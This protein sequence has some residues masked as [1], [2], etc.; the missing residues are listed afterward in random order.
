MFERYLVPMYLPR[1]VYVPIRSLKRVFVPSNSDADAVETASKCDIKGER[2]IEWSFLSKEMPDGPGEAL[3]FGCED[4]YMSLVA[5]QKGFNVLANDLE[6]QV[7]TWKHP[8]VR[9]LEGDFLELELPRNHFDLAINCS[10]VEHVGVAGRYGITIDNESA[11]LQVM[12]KLADVLKPGRTLLM[13]APC[14]QDTILAPWCRVYGAERL[15]KLLERFEIR[16][17]C[18]W[19]KDDQNTWIRSAREAALAFKPRNH[20]T[21]A[22]RC[23]YGLGCFVLARKR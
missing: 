17:E 14:G 5:A 13:T 19:I 22:H 2:N 21:D 7:F 11:D 4:G 12:N 20:P 1:W 16:T 3:E 10:S 15:P 9:F 23:S 8:N 18:Y 6:P